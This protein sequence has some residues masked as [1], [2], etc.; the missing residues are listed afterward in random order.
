MKMKAKK[1]EGEGAREG[2]REGGRGGTYL[3]GGQL[4]DFLSIHGNVAILS[5]V[6][7]ARQKEGREGGREGGW[8]G[9][10]EGGLTLRV[11]NL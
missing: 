8:E 3:A 1:E 7:R 5:L 2:G 6:G 4:I 11:A 9:G 10:R